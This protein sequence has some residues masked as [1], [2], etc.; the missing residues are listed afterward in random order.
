[1][2]QTQEPYRVL[3]FGAGVQSTAL[4]VAA[5]EGRLDRPDVAIFADTGWEPAHT[6][7]HLEAM[8]RYADAYQL[9]I[10]RVSAGNL[11]A[12]ALTGPDKF[13]A[14]P[15]AYRTP[16][17]DISRLRRQCTREYKIAPITKEIR[18]QLGVKPRH[19]VR[20]PVELWIGISTDEAS[21]MKPNWVTWQT[22][23]WPLIELGLNRAACK[24]LIERAGL[25]V[26][27][28]SSCLACPYHSNGYFKEMKRDRPSEW[29]DVV[30]FDH[31]I[32][33]LH[34]GKSSAKIQTP[35]YVHRSAT[36]IDAVYLQE[37]QQTLF[38]EECEGYCEA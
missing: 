19:R 28:K 17:G 8:T 9:E 35:L 20:R 15:L 13:A 14:I 2:T 10:V 23:R 21:R 12:T 30:D 22:N 25:P 18:R 1:V 29:A 24:T 38:D 33:A 36:P 37:D 7:A 4:L 26:P 3:S 16:D 5:C 32:R 34:Q 27:G 11:R 31:R 6:Y